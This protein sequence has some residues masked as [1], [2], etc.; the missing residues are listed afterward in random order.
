MTSFTRAAVCCPGQ[1]Q[2]GHCRAYQRLKHV[3][4]TGKFEQKLKQHAMSKCQAAC[5]SHQDTENPQTTDGL[6]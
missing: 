4:L 2:V 6:R 1:L 5:K 3:K